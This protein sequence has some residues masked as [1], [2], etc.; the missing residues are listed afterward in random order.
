MITYY[1]RTSSDKGLKVVQSARVG[2][3][4]YVE[5]PSEEELQSLSDNCSLDIGHLRDALDPYEV[6]RHEVERSST[7][8]FTRVSEQIEDTYTTCPVLFILTPDYLV[9]VV[10]KRLLLFDQIISERKS[11]P[12]TAKT[13]LFLTLFEDIVSVYSSA[14]ARINKKVITLVA[15]IGEIR[16]EDILSLVSQEQVLNEF[17]NAI[18]QTNAFLK[19]LAADKTLFTETDER[20]RMEDLFHATGQLIVLSKSSLTNAKNIR[21]AYTTIMTNNLNRVIKLF[22][23]LTVVLTVPNIFSSFWGMNVSVPLSDNPFAFGI[24]AVSTMLVCA[25]LFYIFQKMRWL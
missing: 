4:V 18:V 22:T 17:L 1:K 12:T 15:N 6:P 10:R 23:T 16:N 11:I 24:I 19:V 25:L 21:D 13:Q 2:F 5:S 3:W 7:Y 8:I 9:T 20:D 14:L